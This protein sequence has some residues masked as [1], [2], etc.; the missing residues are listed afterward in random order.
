MLH[1]WEANS[2]LLY[3]RRGQSKNGKIPQPEWQ[4]AIALNPMAAVA[5]KPVQQ[6]NLVVLNPLAAINSLVRHE[7]E[8][9]ETSV[10]SHAEN[11]VCGALCK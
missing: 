6:I 11:L 10:K 2:S 1:P 4:Q 8:N 7:P 3:L 9:L 5:L